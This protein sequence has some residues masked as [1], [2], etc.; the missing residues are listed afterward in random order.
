M[1][2]I[3]QN[4]HLLVKNHPEPCKAEDDVD[5]LVLKFLERKEC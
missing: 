4:S 3:A 2:E 5:R 1:G